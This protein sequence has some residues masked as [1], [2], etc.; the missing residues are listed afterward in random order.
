[1]R[2][3]IHTPR[4]LI[5]PLL[6][7]LLGTAW[8]AAGVIWAQEAPVESVEYISADELVEIRPTTCPL[9]LRGGLTG[10]LFGYPH[11]GHRWTDDWDR[12]EVLT[13]AHDL[14]NYTPEAYDGYAIS[15]GNYIEAY[16]SDAR[17][18]DPKIKVK[19]T[20]TW[21]YYQG[22][23]VSV[24]DRYSTV[25]NYG[26]VVECSDGGGSGGTQVIDDNG[27]DIYDPDYSGDYSGS[28][29][30]NTGG[31]GGGDSGSGEGSGT[32]FGPGDSTGGETV[33]WGTGKGNGGTSVCGATAVVEYVCIDIMTETGWREWDCGYVTTC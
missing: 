16:Y 33:D 14:A 5:G 22:R 6:W 19:C 9:Y 11:M 15:R 29:S 8:S 30:E 17:W 2:N 1:M 4:L 28:C 21:R 3:S 25:A 23:L 26:T 10:W 18:Y 12:R 31:S 27:Y 24:T 7:M 13:P 20:A 32:Q